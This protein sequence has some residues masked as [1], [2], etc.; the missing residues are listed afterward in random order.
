VVLETWPADSE[1]TTQRLGLSPSEAPR[2][3]RILF[4]LADKLTF[5]ERAA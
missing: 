5:L 2:L 3:A 1:A 4:R